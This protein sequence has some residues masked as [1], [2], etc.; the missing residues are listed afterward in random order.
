MNPLVF[1]N[2]EPVEPES[3]FVSAMDRGFLYGDAL[4]ETVPVYAGHPFRLNVHIDR[5]EN[6]LSAIGIPV[7]DTIACVQDNVSAALSYHGER[8]GILRITVSRGSSARG[9]S[10]GSA[11]TPTVMVMTFPLIKLSNSIIEAGA[12]VVSTSIRRPHPDSIP[13][14]LKSANYLPNILAYQQA[15][16]AS[17]HEAL[18]LDSAGDSYIEGTVSNIF[19]VKDDLLITPPV[20]LGPL[21]GV[22]RALI[23]EIATVANLAISEQPTPLVDLLDADEMFYTNSIATI[24]PVGRLD[25]KIFSKHR[26][27]T[28]KLE[29]LAQE[30]IVNECSASHYLF[31]HQL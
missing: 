14:F 8:S 24:V 10:T 25:D 20:A 3:V 16:A 4:F 22:T 27:M 12:T 15:E 23:L 31:R 9:L 7:A 2:G 5:M 17:A 21:P 11:K 29:V 13:P 1:V 6:G 26:P 30:Q 18:L 28:R 19:I